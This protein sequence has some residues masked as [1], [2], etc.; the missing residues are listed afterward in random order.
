[1]DLKICPF[2]CCSLDKN[3]DVV[4]DLACQDYDLLFLQETFVTEDRLGDLAFIDENYEAVGSR[5][6]YF[7]R[8]IESN[9]GRC[10]GG[11]ACLWKRAALLGLI[12][13]L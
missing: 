7:E 2:N 1:M 10:E 4:R 11:M 3:I 13:S 5:A 12:R 9:A 6:V 8:A